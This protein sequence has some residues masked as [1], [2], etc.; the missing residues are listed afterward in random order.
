MESIAVKP[1]AG[2]I[3]LIEVKAKGTTLFVSECLS[4]LRQN[5]S[6]TAV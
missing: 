2:G 5:D 4:R 3:V 6:K 1:T